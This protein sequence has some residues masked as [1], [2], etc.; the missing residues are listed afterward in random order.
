MIRFAV[1][2]PGKL[3]KVFDYATRFPCASG[4]GILREEIWQDESGKVVKYNLAFINHALYRMDNG[5]VLGY[6]NAYGCH[7]RHFK[8]K[9]SENAFVDYETL[10]TRFYA[11]VA[12]LRKEK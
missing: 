6:D 3:H 2:K 4:A 7:E 12:A 8:G 1:G 9:V 5:R 10:A 11:E